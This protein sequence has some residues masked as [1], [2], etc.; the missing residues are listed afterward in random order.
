MAPPNRIGGLGGL[1]GRGAGEGVDV[2]SF[3]RTWGV[4][5]VV[6]AAALASTLSCGQPRKNLDEQPGHNEQSACDERPGH[7]EQPASPVVQATNRGVALMGQYKYAEAVAAFEEAV[8]L[9]P[10]SADARVNLAIAV[11]NRNAKGDL[12]QAE[13]LLDA[14]LA[15][16][17]DHTRALYFRGITHQFSGRDEPAMACFQRVLQA[18]PH[19]AYAWYLL[20]RSKSHL[21]QPCRHELERAIEENP[22]LVSAH[23]DLMRVAAQEGDKDE[24]RARQEVFVKLRQSPLAEM[25]TVPHYGRMGPLA[26][27]RPMSG[28]AKRSVTSGELSAGQPRTLLRG[29]GIEIVHPTESGLAMADVNGDGYVD[30]AVAHPGLSDV[31]LLLGKPDGTVEDGTRISNLG[32]AGIALACAFGDYDNDGNVDL[33]VSCIGPNHL[34]RGRGDGTFED[35]TDK[36]G[37]GGPDVVSRSSAFLDADHDADLDI[38]VCSDPDALVSTAW[39]V[40]RRPAGNQ[41]LNNNAD[42]TFTDIAP[43]ASVA[44]DREGGV[45]TAPIDIDGDRDSDLAVLAADSPVRIFL[46]DRL[47]KYHLAQITAEPISGSGG[48]VSQDF[49]GDGRPDLLTGHHLDARGRLYLSDETQLLKPSSRFD[50]CLDV[51]ATWGK[52]SGPRVMDIDLDGDL[53][54]VYYGHSGHVLLNDGWGRFVVKP[55]VWPEVVTDD[56]FA[57]AWAD[58]TGDGVP[59]LL[60]VTTADGG[61]V[62]LIPTKLDPPGN[63]LAISPTGK[64]GDDKRTRSPA[65]GY[66]TRV[67]V[68]RGLHS[69]V[70]TYTGLDGGLS[71]SHMPLIL[72]LGG[73]T[74][75]D[76][77]SL[78]WPDGVT[79]CEIDL[80]AN[81]HHTISEIERRVSSCPVLF[82]WDGEHFG[83]IGDFAGVGGLGYYVAPGE[84]APPQPLEHVRIKPDQLTVRNGVYELRLC[85]P[86]EEVAYIDRLELLAVDHPQDMAVYPDERLAIG[87]PPPTHRLLTVARPVFPVKAT[88]PDGTDCTDRLAEVDRVYAY[89]PDLDPRFVGFCRPHALVLDFGDR[90]AELPPGEDVYLFLTG[91]IEY[92]YSQT[93]YA[94]GQAAVTWQPMKIERQTPDGQWQTIVPDAGAPGGIGRTI[95]IPLLRESLVD[96]PPN[97]KPL[98]GQRS[99]TRL[100]ITTNLEIYH[101]QAFIAADRGTADL[102]IT[103]A[104]LV[105]ADLRRLGFPLEYSPDGHHPTIYTYDVIE[106]TSSFK[107]PRG[108]YTRYGPV[109]DLLAAFDDEYVILGSGDEIALGFDANSLPPI[110]HDHVRSFILVS[111]AYCKD[112]DLYTAEPD[113]VEPLPFRD[114]S[115]YPYPPEEHYPDDSDARRRWREYNSRPGR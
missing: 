104:P 50:E 55:N 48:I 108:S 90:L 78:T 16:Q 92:P 17:P 82:A 88:A 3:E 112:M 64:R 40:A 113:T 19:D 99:N 106:P 26:M 14:V 69:Q 110:A 84:Y 53:D 109:D 33:F 24:V 77:V 111:H 36:T 89:Q 34:F 35:A 71:Q 63:W 5:C 57:V 23:Y 46:N 94:A 45:M 32:V 31:V 76:Y 27:V 58:L 44:Y 30:I 80:A 101:D 49:N 66:G 81:T 41:L 102:T 87:G 115:S 114:M 13:T 1:G 47:G 8:A 67:E 103:T 2:R 79:Q 25:V 15:D 60:R 105:R 96:G 38:Y 12:P 86:M 59:D 22:A 93:T 9:E 73:A 37:T 21:G 75:A 65:S 95:T 70:V 51:L 62:E 43:G 74:K 61:T 107:M 18:R 91:P 97:G 100:R 6:L 72:G 11:W 29:F 20:A 42:G 83:F 28:R 54:L 56:T 52:M 4:V 7:N 85:E 68:R 10:D 98:S 39:G